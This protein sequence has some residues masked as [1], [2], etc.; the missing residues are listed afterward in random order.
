MPASA[1]APKG[2]TFRRLRQS[3]SAAAVAGQLLDV[4]QEVVRGQHRLGALEMR[5]A[6]QDH[7]AVPL[8]GRDEGALQGEQPRVDPVQSVAGPELDV[9]DDLI[10][11]APRRVQLPADVTEPLDQCGFDVHVDV[12]AFQDEREA[13]RLDFRLNLRQSSHNSAGI[14]RE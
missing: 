14:R 11:A 10:V 7:V 13:A 9:G 1:A 6:G 2:K 4:G 12:F 3:A 8:G 5:V